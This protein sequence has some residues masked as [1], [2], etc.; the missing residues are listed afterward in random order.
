M[1]FIL[2]AILLTVVY[3]WEEIS[4]G[5][6][7]IIQKGKG[8]HPHH[9]DYAADEYVVNAVLF[10]AIPLS[11]I[12]FL[13]SDHSTTTKLALLAGQL[14]LVAFLSNAARIFWNRAGL[15]NKYHGLEKV[16]AIGFALSGL[17]SPIMHLFSYTARSSYE[18][19]GKFAALLSLPVLAGL[20]I[21]FISPKDILSGDVLPNTNNLIVVMVGGLMILI[22]VQTLEKHF[23]I[24][25]VKI[26][27]FIRIL[28][29]ILILFVL[30]E[31]LF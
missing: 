20:V 21:T 14:I 13:A 15:I 10:F 12:Y 6:L 18:V 5:I 17:V 26:F 3:S 28:I 9:P 30:G 11:L 24:K 29:G 22:A 19:I 16:G 31:G 25:H 7:Q 1:R 23:H 4:S 8:R 2:F 27:T